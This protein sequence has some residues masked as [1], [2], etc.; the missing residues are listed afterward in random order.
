MPEKKPTAQELPMEGKPKKNYNKPKTDEQKA[1][2]AALKAYV[3]SKVKAKAE[4]AQGIDAQIKAINS[5][6]ELQE[7]M[8]KCALRING[9]RIHKK[10]GE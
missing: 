5:I 8:V 4:K 6:E 2:E 7:I 3:N 9:L 1:L 10:K